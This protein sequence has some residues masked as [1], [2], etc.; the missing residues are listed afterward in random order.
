MSQSL[1]S[2]QTPAAAALC[3]YSLPCVRA[4]LLGR[5]RLH[6]WLHLML[7]FL[8]SQACLLRAV[9]VEVRLVS[10][11][12]WATFARLSIGVSQEGQ[13]LLLL[14]SAALGLLIP[15]V[16]HPAVIP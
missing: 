7:H 12:P 14:V 15:H 16:E 10:R 11:H 3:P 1:S 9:V 5:H 4:A 6:V 13:P 2:A 8:I